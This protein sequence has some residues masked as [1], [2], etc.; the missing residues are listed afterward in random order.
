MNYETIEDESP[1][2][3]L[4]WAMESNPDSDH[5][6]E[7]IAHVLAAWYV[8]PQSYDDRAGVWLVEFKDGLRVSMFGW[9]DT[10]GWSCQSGLAF[11]PFDGWETRLRE[12]WDEYAGYEAPVEDIIASL[13]AQLAQSKK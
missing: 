7:D 13:N 9:H 4:K 2:G 5:N 8:P 6:Y 10:S 3:E 12:E 1:A 11:Y